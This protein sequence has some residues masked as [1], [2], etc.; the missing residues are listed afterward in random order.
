VEGSGVGVT[1]DDV[2]DRWAGTRRG[3]VISGWVRGEA[4]R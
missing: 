2:A 4:A 3:P 1:R